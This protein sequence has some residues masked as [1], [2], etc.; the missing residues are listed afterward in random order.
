[1]ASDRK[2]LGSTSGEGVGVVGFPG[3]GDT[4]WIFRVSARPWS[5]SIG[6]DLWTSTP[7]RADA[8]IQNPGTFVHYANIWE[9]GR[10]HV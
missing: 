7:A 5:G 6:M 1:M 10:A 9:I 2:L 8:E 4:G 3:P